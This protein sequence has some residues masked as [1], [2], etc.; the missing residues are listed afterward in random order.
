MTH[1]FWAG[2]IVSPLLILLLIAPLRAKEI[3]GENLYEDNVQE[4]VRVTATRTQERDIDIAAAV[5]A[6]DESL[7]LEHA[8]DVISE[9]LRGEPGDRIA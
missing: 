9:L 6:I 4:Q 1:H 3:P 2:L 8:P 5:T 7:V